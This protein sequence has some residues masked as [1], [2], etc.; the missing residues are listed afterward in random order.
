MVNYNVHTYLFGNILY[1]LICT[2]LP[3]HDVVF[4]HSGNIKAYASGVL[5]IHFSR[6]FC[7]CE[8]QTDFTEMLEFSLLYNS[9]KISKIKFIFIIYFL[10]FDIITLSLVV[11]KKIIKEML[12]FYCLFQTKQIP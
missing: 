9:M 1:C 5:R 11:S 2:C 12:V 6:F 4:K 8:P 3:S 7:M 10:D